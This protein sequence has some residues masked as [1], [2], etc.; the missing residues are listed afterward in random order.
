MPLT[1]IQRWG[2]AELERPG[3]FS[4]SMPA[5]LSARVT[6]EVLRGALRALVAGH[7]QLRARQRRRHHRDQILPHRREV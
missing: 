4:Q 3:W 7:E 5:R 2:F 1:P 6:P